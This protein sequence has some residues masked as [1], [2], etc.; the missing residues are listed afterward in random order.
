[1]NGKGNLGSSTSQINWNGLCRFLGYLV[2]LDATHQEH[3]AAVAGSIVWLPDILVG[4]H[5]A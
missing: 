4:L 1:M 5:I 2:V 3:L